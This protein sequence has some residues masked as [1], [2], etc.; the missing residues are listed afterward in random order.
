MT[1]TTTTLPGT[2]HNAVE[3]WRERFLPD[4]D[5]LLESWEKFFPNDERFRLCAHRE[6]G[7][8]TTIEVGDEHIDVKAT[9]L[10]SGPERDRLYEAHAKLM[11]GFRDYPKKTTRVIP[12]VVLERIPPSSRG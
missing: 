7:M 2:F 6:C 8:C 11:P 5:L 4:Y 10:A 1:T 9:P 12:V 3:R